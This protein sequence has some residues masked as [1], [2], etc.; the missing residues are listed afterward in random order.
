MEL[1]KKILIGLLSIFCVVMS[2]SVF[3]A[4]DINIKPRILWGA[5]ESLRYMDDNSTDPVLLDVDPAV[6]EKYKSE[7]KYARVV[8]KDDAGNKYRWPLQYTEKVTKFIIHHTATTA[9]LDDPA[10][11]IRSIYY[12]HAVTRAWGDIGYNYIIDTQGNIYEGRAGGEMVIGAHAGIGNN[13]SIGI[14][15]LGNYEEN[16]VPDAVIATLG[17]LIGAKAKIYNI[18]PLGYSLFRGQLLPNIMGHKDIDSTKCPGKYMYEKLPAIR[19]VAASY[20]PIEKPKFVNDYD[21][22]DTSGLYYLELKPG[23]TKSVTIKM[24][25]IGK[26]TWDEKTF[27]VAD[28]NSAFE[29]VISF[30]DSDEIVLAHMQEKSVA[31]SGTATF[32]FKVKGGKKGDIVNM[33]IAPLINGIT[34]PRDYIVLPIAVQ[35]TDYKYEFVD[36]KYPAMTMQKGEKFTAT[37][38]LKNTGNTIWRKSGENTVLLGA[39]H[40]RDR[41][42]NFVSPTSTRI[43]YLN[44][45]EVA[46]G[47]TG[48]FIMSLQA[49]A[50]IGYYKEYFTPVVEG[51]TW[52]RDSGTY[53]ETTVLGGDYETEILGVTAKSQWEQGKKY[54]VEVKLRNLGQKTWTKKNMKITIL[55]EDSLTVSNAT[56]STDSVKPGEIG[57]VTFDGQV[58]KN[59]KLGEKNILIKLKVNGVSLT[60]R[61]IPM[62]YKVIQGSTK[63]TTTTSSTSTQN[64]TSDGGTIRVKLGF[65]GNPQITSDGE[66]GVYSGT[67]LIDTLTGGKI[68]GVNLVNGNYQVTIGE[69]IYTR[70]DPIRFI[71]SSGA[72]MKIANFTARPGDNLYR[73]TLEVRT[74]DGSLVVIDELSLENYMKGLAEMPN[75]EEPEKLKAVIVAARSYAKFYMT[76]AEKF[77]GKPYNLDDNPNV[78]QK[79]LG[80]GFEKRAPNVVTA[81]NATKGE[82]V[83]YKGELVK[84]PYFSQSDGKV[85]KSAKAVW[86]WDAPYLVSVDDSMCKA[87]EFKGHGVGLSGCGARAMAKNGSTYKEILTHY[88]TGVEITDLY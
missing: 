60:K 52:M 65:T 2:E 59:A 79:Y 50:Q 8:T 21:Y 27:I 3:A 41:N 88:Y 55:K 36:A 78:S 86:N 47:G 48:T 4:T 31:S 13:G 61:Q 35:Q 72:I 77:P 10:K 44:E 7:L 80:Y 71:P 25:N 84:T 24:E 5:D 62:H 45:E 43:G 40:E 69:K 67:K 14:S 6:L 49:P 1:V 12:Y 9:D 32:I 54:T 57:V 11:A 68:V 15:V 26:K 28:K 16:E 18:D 22:Q 73:G 76:K 33:N 34:K 64:N 20:K 74:D 81:V 23:E 30:P 87:T 85:T 63:T 42:S 53:F 29:G 66:F 82:V 58:A 39:D 17:K 19:A 75:D 70:I 37:I 51:V 56:L 46:P 83:T 38:K